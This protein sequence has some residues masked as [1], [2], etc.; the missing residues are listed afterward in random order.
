[1]SM[2]I[3]RLLKELSDLTCIDACGLLDGVQ[4]EPEDCL[5]DKPLQVLTEG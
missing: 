4:G 5:A 2:D 1:M 3:R